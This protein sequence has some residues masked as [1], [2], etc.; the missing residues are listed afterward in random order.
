MICSPKRL[1]SPRTV[2]I[3]WRRLH[4]P[5]DRTEEDGEDGIEHDHE[6][7]RLDDGGGRAQAD[8]LR[9]AFDQHALEAARQGDDEAEDRRLDQADPQIG[10]RDDLLQ[11]LNVGERRNA[12]RQPDE[13]AAAEKR[14]QH[15]PEGEQRHHDHGRDQA[16][17][18]QRLDRRHAD[19]PHRV[20]LFGDLHRSELRREGRAGT[21]GDHDR[22]H[23]SAQLANRDPPDEVDRVDLRSE[24]LE[25][26]RALLADDDP[27]QEAH[28]ADDPERPNADHVEA[29]DDRVPAELLR[30]LGQAGEAEEGCAEETEQADERAPG[31]GDPLA[32]LRDD[33]QEAGLL[34]GMDLDRLV[35]LGDLVE[36]ALRFGSRASH[37]RLAIAHRAIDE[38]CSDR[39]HSL[40][41][42]QVDHQRIGLGIDLALDARGARD[43]QRAANAEWR[44]SALGGGC[45]GR[46]HAA[47]TV[48]SFKLAGKCGARPPLSCRD[49]CLYA[50]PPWHRP[51]RPYSCPSGPIRRN[52]SEW[53][54][55]RAPA[56]SPRTS[57]S[58]AGDEGA[59]DRDAVLANMAFAWDPA[60]LR[61]ISGR[62]GTVLTLEGAPVLAHV[63]AGS[64]ATAVT[65]AMTGQGGSLDGLEQIDAESCRAQQFRIAQAR[66]AVRHAAR[67]R[68]PDR[69]RARSLRRRL[70]GRDRRPDP[71]FVA[72]ARLPPDPLGGAG[73]AD[74]EHGHRRSAR[75]AA[76]SLSISSGSAATGPGSRPA[77]FS[78]CS[79]RSTGSSRAAPE[80]RRS[81]AISSTTASTSFIRPSGG[82]RGSTGLA[83]YG[84]PLEP[85]Y[86]AMLL[87]AIVGG[88]VAQ[89]IIEGIFMR[90]FGKMHIHVW[91]PIDSKFRLITA[92]RN[93]NMV[94]LVLR[95][96]VRPTRRRDRAGRALDA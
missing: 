78:W 43:G 11:S 19:R 45:G 58:K 28:Q 34:V 36:Q 87:W 9:I 8:F 63:A 51:P 74:P 55:A 2:M 41:A 15:R 65:Q 85:V 1:A 94:I 89:R 76:C 81:G 47:R 35:E 21:A 14:H 69:G 30:P 84:T 52:C 20:D 13:D 39:V 24:L 46:G 33:A 83:A 95:A 12:E 71:L 82:G 57:A 17:N 73:R 6:E 77:S 3:G 26:D 72:Q 67:S 93:P 68:Q 56:A 96:P 54:R 90:R 79:T 38:P 27:D 92:R 75:W 18:D 44:I 49:F 10:E 53:T 16:G 48:P 61:E 22:G 66:A 32:Q 80:L 5:S 59:A 64:D 91:R 4:Q 37:L 25:L 42:R 50:Q 7:D 60:W 70:Q 62:P 29:L 88:Y 31:L 86:S 40:D 23:Q